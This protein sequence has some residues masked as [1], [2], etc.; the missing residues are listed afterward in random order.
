ML[1]QVRI[2]QWFQAKLEMYLEFRFRV[3]KFCM[4]NIGD[5][6][7]KYLLIIPKYITLVT[8]KET[9]MN[10]QIFAIS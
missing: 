6:N 3:L 4:I 9:H 10:Q 7:S 2:R 1:M 5:L 8:K